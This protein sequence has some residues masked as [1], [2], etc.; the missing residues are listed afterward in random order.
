MEVNGQCCNTKI[1]G[2]FAICDKYMEKTMN[3]NVFTGHCENV[4][5]YKLGT[6]PQPSHSEATLCC[7]NKTHISKNCFTDLHMYFCIPATVCV[8]VC[9]HACI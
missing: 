9:A 5:S 2:Q 1:K 7:I 4:L 3:K 6:K 8:C